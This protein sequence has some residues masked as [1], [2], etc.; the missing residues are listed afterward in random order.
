VARDFVALTKPRITLIVLITFAA[1]VALA[2]GAL[3]LHDGVLAVLG[4]TLVVAA[5]NALNMWWERDVDALMERT[6]KRP[7][8]AGRLDPRAA[9]AFG[10]ALGAIAVPMLCAVN[11]LTGL[12]GAFALFSYVALYTPLK[13]RTPF[14]LHVGAVPGAIP[15]LLGWTSVTGQLDGGGL[16]LFA[17]MCAWQLPHFIAISVFRE[18]DYARAG[19]KVHGVVQSTGRAWLGL[20][21]WTVACVV[22]SVLPL[23]FGLGGYVYL[24]VAF[25]AGAWFLRESFRGAWAAGAGEAQSHRAARKVFGFSILYMVVTFVALVADRTTLSL[26]T[27]G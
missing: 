24:A 9:L 27:V 4:T 17:F 13:R 20:A 12:L 1:G 14:S 21:L 19:L 23:F 11:P 15:P 3:T 26:P 7:L 8:P 10:C 5:A 6:R 22:A 25:V 16:A 18:A 2:P